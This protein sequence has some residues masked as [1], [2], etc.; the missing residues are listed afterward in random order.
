MAIDFVN[1]QLSVNKITFLAAF[2][3]RYESTIYI[4][5]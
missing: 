5:T 1:E 2:V 3:Y 4:F